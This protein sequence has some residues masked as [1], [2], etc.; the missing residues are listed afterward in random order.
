MKKIAKILVLG[1]A[2][3]LFAVTKSNAQISVNVQLKR[4]AQYEDNERNHPHRPSPNHVWVAEEWVG[5]G[6]GGYVYRPG[7]WTLPPAIHRVAGYWNKTDRGWVWVPGHWD[8]NVDGGW[9]KVQ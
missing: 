4:P 9:K 7:F 1:A 8:V 5:N 6:R 2:V 3:S